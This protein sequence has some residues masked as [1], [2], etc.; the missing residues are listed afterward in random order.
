MKRYTFIMSI[1]AAG[2]ASAFMACSDDDPE[3]G[4]GT[5]S[6]IAAATPELSTLVTALQT[7]DLVGTLN[8]TGP[9]TV[10]APTDTA[11]EALP[12]GVLQ[13][14][15]DDTAELTKVL[16]YH[17]V[18]QRVTAA[19]VAALQSATTVQGADVAIRVE[20]G[21]VFINESRVTTTD[22]EASNGIIHLIDAVLIPPTIV[23]IAASNSNFSTLVQAVQTANLEDTLNGTGPFTVF[24]PTDA[25]F[26]A[27]PGTTLDDLLANPAQLA[28]VLT[29]HVVSGDVRSD[30]ARQLR[31]AITV[32]GTSVVTS[33]MGTGLL[34]NQAVVVTP[35]IVAGNG[36][37]HAID[38]VLLPSNIV[39]LAGFDPRLSTLVT[40]V[41][42][43]NLGGTLSG[44]GP[45]TLFAPSDSAFDA[46][47]AGTLDGLL[48]NIPALTNVLTYHVVAGRALAADLS[49]ATSSATLQSQNVTFSSDTSGGIQVNGANVVT[50]DIQGTN[51]VIHVIDGVLLPSD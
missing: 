3:P 10:F 36:V 47:P 4:P 9:F 34:I 46:L 27:L 2:A 33:T 26:A 45:F 8:G 25:A 30:A 35:D 20:G 19:E 13:G 42:A 5:I 1:A 15:L 18:P 32:Q 38:A 44:A 40:A 37:I 24:A 48:A 31:S 39:Q 17:V 50:P 21:T 12:A 28:E 14:L 43:A 51:G 16:T 41:G 6:Q 23:D 49:T 7:A 22:I 29:Y 11:F